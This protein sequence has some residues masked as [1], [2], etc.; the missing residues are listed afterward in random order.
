MDGTDRVGKITSGDKSVSLLICAP[1]I[2]HG[3]IRIS[4]RVPTVKV[5]RSGCRTQSGP[6]CA[7]E[8]SRRGC[9]D[10]G[11]ATEYRTGCC[12]Q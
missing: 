1:Q 10:L 5:C 2:P 3:R 6:V 4:A 9:T 12:L 11:G 7:C 8:E